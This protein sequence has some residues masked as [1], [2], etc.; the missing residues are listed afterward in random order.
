[1]ADTFGTQEAVPETTQSKSNSKTVL[2]LI[3]LIA[4]AGIGLGIAVA[5][6]NKN[7]KNDTPVPANQVTTMTDT[8]TPVSTPTDTTPPTPEEL[9]GR[10]ESRI[11]ELSIT[12]AQIDERVKG[13]SCWTI[14]DGT[15]YDI[16]D[17]LRSG[18][19]TNITE[20]DIC[21]KDGTKILTEERDGQPPIKE[22]GPFSPYSRPI[23]KLV[24]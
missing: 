19:A 17:F 1:M 21:G 2:I 6:Q 11:P 23:G 3:I 24:K 7:N 8:P 4:L 9:K 5:T 12:Q 20:E 10:R 15:V 16:S 18:I 13:G 14:I 22:V